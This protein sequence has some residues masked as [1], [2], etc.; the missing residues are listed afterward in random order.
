MCCNGFMSLKRIY[1]KQPGDL[2]WDGA[3]NARHICSVFYRMGRHEW[4][5]AQGWRQMHDAGVGKVIDLRNPGEIRRREHDPAVPEASSAGIELVNLPLEEPGN[6]RFDSVAVPYMNHTGM[7]KLV[8]EE[9][10]AHLREV[11]E[12]LA[13]AQGLVVI[14]C[15][16]GR[17]RSGLIA[18]M[19]LDLAGM[20]D[21]ILLHDELAVR[22]I[23]EWHRISPRKHP[24]ERFRCE[25]ELRPIIAERAAE[26]EKF[27]AWLGSARSYLLAQG[28]S[29]EAV[30]R[31][32][33]LAR[34]EN[35]WRPEG[36]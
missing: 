6:E 21:R 12:Q 10:G 26:L 11:F 32:E 15:S 25:D 9:F 16:A 30:E 34:R 3:V 14:H 8:C 7:Y 2:D 5:T 19:L 33:Q 29:E 4:L 20:D 27:C 22:G 23:N 36:S 18:T 28:M 31:L 24:D 1:R 13:S 35:S 17:D